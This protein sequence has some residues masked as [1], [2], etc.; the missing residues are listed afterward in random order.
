MSLST[1]HQSILGAFSMLGGSN[2]RPHQERRREQRQRI[3]RHI[4]YHVPPYPVCSVGSVG[5]LSRHGMFIE[6]T[7]SACPG[8]YIRGE[9]RVGGGDGFE[10]FHFAGEVMWRTTYSRYRIGQ[11]AGLGIRFCLMNKADQL[12]IDKVLQQAADRDRAEQSTNS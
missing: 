12:K 3:Q 10:T 5:D 7:R 8:S 9:V 4:R 6:T 2:A 11:R 1:K